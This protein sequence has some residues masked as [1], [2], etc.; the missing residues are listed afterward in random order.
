MRKRKI[1]GGS[2]HALDE[3]LI[4]LTPLIDVVFVVLV[5]FILIAPLLEVDKI[6]LA[7]AT[8]LSQKDISKK[9]K[10]V[11][12]VREDNSVWVNNRVVTD[13]ELLA[14]LRQA[15]K[16]YPGVPPQLFHDK[17]AFFGTYQKVK[18]AT[19]KAGFL[20]LDVILQGH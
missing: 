19:E 12:Y 6:E 17:K 13:V 14:V 7:M 15:K 10:V 20:S 8:E 16:D 1:F 3:S 9:S 4:N 11:I 18:D 5:A 2:R